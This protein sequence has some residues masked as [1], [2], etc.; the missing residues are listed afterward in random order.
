MK[1]LHEIFGLRTDDTQYRAKLKSRIQSTFGDKIYFL[2]VT[3][4]IPEVMINTDAIHSHTVFNDRDHIIQQAA[5]YLREDILAFANATPELSWPIS[6]NDLNSIAREPPPSIDAF[7]Q[8]LLTAKEHSVNDKA[9]RLIKS[10][11]ADLIHGVTKGKFITSRHFLLGLGLHN[12]TGQK[13]PIKIA[14][15][16]GHCIDYDLVC[17]IETAQAEAAQLM[18]SMNGMLPIKPSMNDT[19]VLTFYWLDNIDTQ[20]GHGAINSTHMIA[21]QEESPL[22]V[23]PQQRIEFERSRRRKIELAPLEQ[24]N[25]FVDPKKEPPPM[26]SCDTEVHVFDALQF[27][28]NHFV[29]VTILLT[30]LPPIEAKVTEFATI[31]RYMRYLQN[32]S[33]DVNMPYVNVTLDVGAAMNAYKLLWNYPEQFDNVLIHLGDF[34]FMKENFA[35]IGKITSGS[36][37]EDVI[38]QANVCSSS[39][40]NGVLCGNHYNRAWTVHLALSEVLERLLIER[41]LADA[42][43]EIPK[44][45]FEIVN[46]S[47]SVENNALPNNDS[48]LMKYQQFKDEIRNGRLLKLLEEKG[49]SVQAQS[50]YPHRV[51]INQRGKQTLNREAKKT[52][53]TTNFAPDSSGILKWTLNRAEQAKNTNALLSLADLNTQSTMYKPLRPSQ[54]LKS[55]RFVDSIMQVLKEEYIN[56]FDSEIEKDQLWNLSSGIPAPAAVAENAIQLRHLGNA[57][58]EAFEKHRI[59]EADVDFHSRIKRMNLKLFKSTSRNV[60]AKS[61]TQCKSVEANRNILGTLLAVSEKGGRVVDFDVALRYPLCAVPRSL[62]NPDGSRRITTKTRIWILADQPIIDLPDLSQHG[63]NI[64]SEIKWVEN[65]FLNEIE[66]LLVQTNN[67][68]VFEDGE[69]SDEDSDD[70]F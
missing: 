7:L 48:F 3:K 42:E 18:A 13:K 11:S 24:Q 14:N 61:S 40:L 38:F 19:T 27:L 2:T 5:K 29:W 45:Y 69:E 46:D 60:V 17:E 35:V 51:A 54:I 55:E 56:P 64:A 39:S 8:N 23:A 16:L 26:G 65:P 37:I 36:G 32:L 47:D 70:D 62:V 6:L 57:A 68:F 20:T 34:H 52:G 22:S 50:K 31:H 9:S 30:Y 59:Q 25:I 15:H 28:A 33:A 49:M 63:W 21:F 1:V 43:V 41:F 67:E 12:I 58:Y 53:G 44:Q 10:Y 4:N 66:E